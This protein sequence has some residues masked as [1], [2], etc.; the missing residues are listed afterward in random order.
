MY[1]TG[2]VADSSTF[3]SNTYTAESSGHTIPDLNI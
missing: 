2:E 1:G 3:V